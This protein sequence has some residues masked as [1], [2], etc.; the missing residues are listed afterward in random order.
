MGATLHRSRRRELAAAVPL[1]V[2]QFV[3]PELYAELTGV[4]VSLVWRA[5]ADRVFERGTDYMQPDG[6][7]TLI[8]AYNAPRDKLLALARPVEPR[9]GFIYALRQDTTGA[10]KIGYSDTQ[11][12]INGRLVSLRIGSPFALSVMLSFRGSRA[13]ETAIHDELAAYRLRGEWFSGAP[14]VLDHLRRRASS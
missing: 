1:A 7:T 8:D 5:I 6:E 13:D 4:D 14:A 10:I 2:C 3:T 9:L 12:G 11:Q